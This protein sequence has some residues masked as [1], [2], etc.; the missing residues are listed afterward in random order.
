MDHWV[1]FEQAMFDYGGYAIFLGYLKR[2]HN[3]SR[4]DGTAF[5]KHSLTP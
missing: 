1:I 2:Y 3:I 5:S 4:L